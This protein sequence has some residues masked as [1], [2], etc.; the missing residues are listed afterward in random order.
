MKF[1]ITLKMHMAVIPNGIGHVVKSANI[2]ILGLLGV[3]L[4]NCY[5]E[6]EL[7]VVD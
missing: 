6:C 1:L 7:L 2:N 4:W 3:D 5:N